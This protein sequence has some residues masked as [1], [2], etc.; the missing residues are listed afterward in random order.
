MG[1]MLPNKMHA[2]SEFNSRIIVAALGTVAWH[3]GPTTSFPTN[4]QM[5][6]HALSTERPG[7]PHG[8]D[9]QMKATKKSVAGNQRRRRRN[10][11][12]RSQAQ[13][14]AQ[15]ERT[16]CLSAENGGRPSEPNQPPSPSGLKPLSDGQER[17]RRLWEHKQ[18]ELET[19]WAS[20]QARQA[21]QDTRRRRAI[22]IGCSIGGA[23]LVVLL[24]IIAWF[25]A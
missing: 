2:L 8:Y 14:L 24:C 21:G 7:L 18:G 20:A 25:A 3:A 1:A 10:G 22:K 6:Q 16:R 5:R 15:K 23:V 17:I 11:Q 12:V 13:Q 9:R 19:R 4:R